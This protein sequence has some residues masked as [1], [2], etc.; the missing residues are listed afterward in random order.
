MKKQWLMYILLMTVPAILMLLL[1]YH[2]MYVI[3]HQTPDARVYI[4]IADN[5]VNTGHFIQ[6][7][8]PVEGMVVPPGLPFILTLFRLL[9]FNNGMIIAI[10]ILMFGF[11]NILLYETERTITG[12]GLWAPIIYTM[13]YLRCWI[14]LGDMLVEHYYLF[15][16]CLAI[17]LVYRQMGKRKKLILLNITGLA[18][19]LVRPLLAVVYITVLTYS[20]IWLLKEKNIKSAAG[21]LLLPLVI[22]SI[23]T[24]VNY[25]ETGEF[26]LL[27]NYSGSDMYTAS[28]IGSPVKIEEAEKY[29]QDEKFISIVSDPSLTMTQ[30]N[31]EFKK[32]TRENLKDHFVLYVGNGLRRGFEII[33]W[34][35]AGAALYTFAGG[36][37]LARKEIT[38]GE[39]RSL[40]VLI[41]TVLI[42]GMSSFGVSELRYSIVIWPAASIHGAFLTALLAE[43]LKNRL[44]SLN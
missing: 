13:A 43:K 6:C 38:G 32:L 25:R 33:I 19:M 31:D 34:A 26:I 36:I 27:E 8:R 7:E 9:H 16:L 35:Y 30:R 5:F 14:M 11:A 15:L 29:D 28:R 23:N 20:L 40:L 17:W 18:M 4:S 10:Q 24:A 3:G 1:E 42:A 37:L 22:L 41:L 39:K 12:K 44:K 2:Q 21:L